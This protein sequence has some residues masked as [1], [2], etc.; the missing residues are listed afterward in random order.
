M[1]YVIFISGSAHYKCCLSFYTALS[2]AVSSIIMTVILSDL[3]AASAT[4]TTPQLL[5]TKWG[6]A[7]LTLEV[8]GLSSSL[9]PVE[10]AE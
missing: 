4:E 9:L 10:F 6:P 2:E 5:L 8:S 3:T 1:L 7:V